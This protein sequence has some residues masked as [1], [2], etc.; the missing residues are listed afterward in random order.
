VLGRKT[1]TGLMIE[2]HLRAWL[3]Q[4]FAAGCATCALLSSENRRA[5]K[6]SDLEI[7]R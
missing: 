2:S 4:R 6:L 7:A 1:Q 3:L 5:A